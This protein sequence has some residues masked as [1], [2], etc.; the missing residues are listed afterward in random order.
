MKI[1]RAMLLI[2]AFLLLFG[3]SA[4]C[5]QLRIIELKHR[6]AGEII[7]IVK[8]LLGPDDTISGKRY[9]ILLTAA[10]ENLSR[11]EAVIRTLDRAPRQLMIIVVQGQHA[12]EALASVDVSGN[13]S[14]GDQTRLT[15]G[16]KPLSPGTVSAAGRREASGLRN[17]DI[18]RLRVQEGL[19]AFITIGQSIPVSTR[20][21]DP[22]SNGDEVVYQE[23]RTGFRVVP[24]LTGDRFILD[25]TSQRD[26]SSPSEYGT[27]ATQ[28]IQTQAQ[29]KLN[30]WIEIGAV[31][32]LGQQR[33]GGLVYSDQ[34]RR[35][36]RTQVFLTVVEAA[37]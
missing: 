5:G 9:T 2:S 32:G 8:P 13:V 20:A 29:G 7:R 1:H 36:S 12:R 4:H 24:R 23:L 19:P 34:Q 3:A 11:I 15:F 35:K 6:T 30:E 22:R 37:D 21:I 16:R 10:P 33:A 18:Q 14:I 27:V 26:A 28:Q 31:L 25:I 17:V